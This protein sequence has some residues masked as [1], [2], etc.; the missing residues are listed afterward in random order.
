MKYGIRTPNIKK[1]IKARTTGYAKRSL[2]RI[3]PSYGIKGIGLIKS[4]KKSL[5]NHIYN[6]TTISIFNN[7]SNKKNN[8]YSDSNFENRKDNTNILTLIKNKFYNYKIICRKRKSVLKSD[9]THYF[10]IKARCFI[11][12][13][14]L[15]LKTLRGRYQLID[16]WLCLKCQKN[17]FGKNRPVMLRIYTKEDINKIIN[18]YIEK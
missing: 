13:K 10:N 12:D 9:K 3:S 2:K 16:G 4:P 15:G 1:S 17:I 7:H 11:C 5:Y 6:K 18:E 14:D 8:Y